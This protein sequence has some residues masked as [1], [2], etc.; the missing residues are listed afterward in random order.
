VLYRASHLINAITSHM[1][2]EGILRSVLVN[3]PGALGGSQSAT[4][5]YLLLL[6]LYKLYEFRSAFLEAFQV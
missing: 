1:T 3:N 4:H 2:L 5:A 6:C